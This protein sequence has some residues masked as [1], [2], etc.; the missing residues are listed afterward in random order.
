MFPSSTGFR[1]PLDSWDSRTGSLHLPRGAEASTDARWLHERAW[2]STLLSDPT[3]CCQEFCGSKGVLATRALCDRRPRRFHRKRRPTRRC[4]PAVR[5]RPCGARPSTGHANE[6][7]GDVV[8]HARQEPSANRPV[9][10]DAGHGGVLERPAVGRIHRDRGAVA[11]HTEAL[12]AGSI[13]RGADVAE[14]SG[15]GREADGLLA[16]PRSSTRSTSPR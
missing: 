12:G 3:E 13:G 10:D 9:E 2:T 7:D 16:L 8:N 1:H 11:E 4:R 5:R 15:P 6:R 14:A